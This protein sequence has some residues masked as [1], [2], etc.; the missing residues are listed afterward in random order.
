MRRKLLNSP[1]AC[2]IVSNYAQLAQQGLQTGSPA[3]DENQDWCHDLISYQL[4]QY[5]NIVFTSLPVRKSMCM[6]IVATSISICKYSTLDFMN[7]MSEMNRK[8]FFHEWHVQYLWTNSNREAGKKRYYVSIDIYFKTT[9]A[10]TMR[11]VSGLTSS[12]RAQ[13]VNGRSCCEELRRGK[14]TNERHY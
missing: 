4:Y 11:V 1:A 13:G 7:E 14:H 5:N 10:K 9:A 3:V 2:R 12:L 6:H 8:E